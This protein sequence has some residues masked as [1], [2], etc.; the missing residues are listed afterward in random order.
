MSPTD[1]DAMLQDVA[2]HMSRSE[3][4]RQLSTHSSSTSGSSKRG[5]AR[6][7]K[8]TSASNSPNYVQRRR[9]TANHTTRSY[10][11]T[12]QQNA[13]QT[14]EQRVLNCYN[15]KQPMSS[16]RPM[17]WH[18]GSDTFVAPGSQICT[19][20]PALGNAI[21]DMEN[22]AVSGTPAS[23][24]EQS[25]QNAFAMGYG[26]PTSTPNTMYDTSPVDMQGCGMFGVGPEAAC[27][28]Y[29][30][31]SVSDQVQYPYIP[32]TEPYM[33]PNSCY[34]T[35][36]QW[37]QNSSNYPMGSQMPQAMSEYA[38]A[39][40][41]VNSARKAKT[42]SAPQL[43]R[44]KSKE[45]VGMGLY[46]DRGSTFMSGLN[47]VVS[48]ESNRDSMG[49][50]LKLEETWQPPNDDE[51]EEDDDGYSTEEAEEVEE[52]PPPVMA[53]APAEAQ[54]AFYPAYRDMS[55]QSFFFNDDED[56]TNEDHYGNYLA[57]GKAMPEF[58]PKPQF[59]NQ[60][61]N[62]VWF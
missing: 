33:Y 20:E 34:Q 18:P 16:S 60:M 40:V 12:S 3:L 26:Y 43:S 17:S 35:A 30:I 42:N 49:K 46:D 54:S 52:V 45:L 2:N 25:I 28:S 32:P 57:Y 29:P 6:I 21:A 36:Q 9:T 1:Y 61:E 51:E 24:V 14:R 15:S 8:Q 31:Y 4:L 53:S 44:K 22:L 23:S 7:T 41:P 59:N 10:P 48:E 37:P 62:H 50:G 11:R 47:S 38:P 56:Y 5:S 55:N 19:S 58:R 27:D 13:Y 39:R